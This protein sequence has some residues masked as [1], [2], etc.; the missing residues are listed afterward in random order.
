VKK[1]RFGG[2]YREN[3]MTSSRTVLAAESIRLTKRNE[4][5]GLEHEMKRKLREKF[6]GSK[7]TITSQR[8]AV[9]HDLEAL[10]GQQPSA[11]EVYIKVKKRC[12]RIALG[13]VYNTLSIFE[14]WA[15]LKPSIGQDSRLDMI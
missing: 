9:F 2:L 4:F 13:T 14:R 6:Q 10:N 8:K 7:H 11:D 15:S 5:C 1:A 12:P 3:P